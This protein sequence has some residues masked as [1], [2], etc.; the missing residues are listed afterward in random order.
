MKHH[1]MRLSRRL[2]FIAAGTLF[3]TG[4]CTPTAVTQDPNQATTNAALQQ[5]ITSGLESYFAAQVL[6][7]LQNPQ[8]CTLS[9]G[10]SSL[11]GGF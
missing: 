11:L 5:T 7:Y 9:G 2:A 1:S 8:A 6:Y 10:T 3:T 4:T